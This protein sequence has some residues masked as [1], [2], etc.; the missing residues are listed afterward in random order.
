MK[1]TCTRIITLILGCFMLLTAVI[2]AGALSRGDMVATL[3]DS[4]DYSFYIDKEDM[5]WMTAYY[6]T[7]AATFE[8]AKLSFTVQKRTL[9]IFW[10]TVDIGVVGNVWTD[11]GHE[12]THDFQGQFPADGKGTYRGNFKI[13]IT[14][15]DGTVDTFKRTLEYKVS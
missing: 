11:Y 14:H 3:G 4:L 13:E 12:P 10:T 15:K 7:D 6:S 9:G 2:P 1:T 8:V 5:V